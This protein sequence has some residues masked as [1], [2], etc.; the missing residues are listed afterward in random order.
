M[1]LE[2]HLL[3]TLTPITAQFHPS[4][5][6]MLFLANESPAPGASSSVTMQLLAP[7]V[8]AVRGGMGAS[9]RWFCVLCTFPS[10]ES[11]WESGPGFVLL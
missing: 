9:T 8:M 1:E 3:T 5:I 7:R 10:P 4:P 6:F 11:P 2:W